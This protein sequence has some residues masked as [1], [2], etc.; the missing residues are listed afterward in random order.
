MSVSQ[1][2]VI[3]MNIESCVGTFQLNSG[4]VHFMVTYI[5]VT[6]IMVTYITVTYILRHYHFSLFP[7]KQK[8]GLKYHI[9]GKCAQ[10]H[11][12][13]RNLEINA[14]LLVNVI[15]VTYITFL[16]ILYQFTWDRNE[17]V[18]HGWWNSCALP[19][20]CL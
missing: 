19:L 11:T 7:P 6:Y 18:E 4:N 5:T 15:M 20:C 12:F 1:R 14:L 10:C 2:C 13:K 9:L 17:Y 3:N 16:T 8:D